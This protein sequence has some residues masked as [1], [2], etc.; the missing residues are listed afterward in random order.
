M[1]DLGHALHLRGNRDGAEYA[2]R[3]ALSIEPACVV[4]AYNLG[5]VLQDSGDFEEAIETYTAAL[6]LDPKLADAH[7]N[8]AAIYQSMPGTLWQQSAIRHLNEY[9]KITEGGPKP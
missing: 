3:L 6:E 5:V 9:R 4:A 2:Y 1:V 7:F 8:L